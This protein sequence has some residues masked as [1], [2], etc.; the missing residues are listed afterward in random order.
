MKLLDTYLGV[1]RSPCPFKNIPQKTCVILHA[2]KRASY[3]LL[4]VSVKVPCHSVPGMCFKLGEDG[5]VADGARN[6]QVP[7]AQTCA[8]LG[9]SLRKSHVARSLVF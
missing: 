6:A 1:K 5:D 4:S 3:T 8:S 7:L 9:L 2:S